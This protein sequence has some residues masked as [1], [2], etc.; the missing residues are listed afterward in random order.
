MVIIIIDF[1]IIMTVEEN[2]LRG[3]HIDIFRGEMS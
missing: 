3:V 2:A 1:N